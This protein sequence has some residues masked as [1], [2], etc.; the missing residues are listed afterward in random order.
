MA[1]APTIESSEAQQADFDRAFESLQTLVDFE[2]ANERARND[3][4]LSLQPALC[5]G[6]LSI[7]DSSLTLRL[8][9]R[10]STSL[11]LAQVTCLRTNGLL[12]TVSPALLRLTA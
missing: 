1:D 4:I 2:E 5:F 9:T 10:S 3:P 12:K 11:T 8:R 7:K 6:C